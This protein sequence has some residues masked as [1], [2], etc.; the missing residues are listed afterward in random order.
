MEKEKRVW[1]HLKER[2]FTTVNQSFMCPDCGFIHEFIDGH[3][4][5]YNYCPQCGVKIGFLQPLKPQKTPKLEELGRIAEK[6]TIA[7]PL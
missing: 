2:D 3:T 1:V 7:K 6:S 4:A 5:Q